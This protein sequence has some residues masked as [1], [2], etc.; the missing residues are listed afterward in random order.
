VIGHLSDDHSEA[1]RNNVGVAHIYFNYKEQGSQGL[2]NILGSLIKQLYHQIPQQS[3][4]PQYLEKLTSGRRTPSQEELF[5]ALV[6]TSKPFLQTFL[7]FD[8]LDECDRQTQRQSLLPLLHRMGDK[9]FRIFV[10]SRRYPGD[11]EYN[12]RS[13][14]SIEIIA[15]DDDIKSYIYGKLDADPLAKEMIGKA[16]LEDEFI[17]CLVGT[18]RGMSAPSVCRWQADFHRFTY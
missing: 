9:G 8:A 18:A 5:L 12:F 4:L 6:E 13:V 10:T 11:I 16:V 14:P 3:Q 15:H 7:V 17:A 1:S 2:S